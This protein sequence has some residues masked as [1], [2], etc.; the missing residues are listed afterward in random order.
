VKQQG[1]DNWALKWN[2]SKRVK[3]ELILVL[4]AERQELQARLAASVELTQIREAQVLELLAERHQ[5][6]GGGRQ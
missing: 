2:V 3:D 1:I 5:M 4:E 6:Q